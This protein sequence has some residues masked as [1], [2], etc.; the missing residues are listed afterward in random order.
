M[1]G[2]L[3]LSEAFLSAAPS[4]CT[5]GLRALPGLE[6][7]L[8]ALVAQ[9]RQAHPTLAFEPADFLRHLAAHLPTRGNVGAALDCVRADE[10]LL[11][12]ACARNEPLA[13]ALLERQ[14]FSQ[15]EVW[16]PGED[17]AVVAEVRQRLRQRLL[18]AGNK[19]PPRIATF[20]GRGTL[21]R[22]ARAIATRLLIDLKQESP[23]HVSLEEASPEAEALMGRDPELSFI[24]SR[25]QEDFRQAFQEA[26][27]TLT[28]RERSLLRLHHVDNLS[29][30]SV[31]IMYQMSR[32]TAARWIV[33]AREHL[34]E[35]TREALAAR[36]KLEPP[37]LESLLGLLRSHLEVSL[38]RLLQS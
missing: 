22:W 28:P 38:H 17:S 5:P 10:L 9:A 8:G 34:I 32:S 23:A 21:A 25:Y 19:R 24:R 20:S 14:V 36:L 26:L 6:E 29:V 7:T 18:L 12:F 1:T 27:G 37:E 15:V 30:D 13:L 16:L 11:A 31:G 4:G 2:E 3:A 33:Q 35:R